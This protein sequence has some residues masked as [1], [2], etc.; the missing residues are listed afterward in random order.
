MQLRANDEQNKHY[1]IASA[2][3]LN[4]SLHPRVD[5]LFACTSPGPSATGGPIVSAAATTMPGGR[6]TCL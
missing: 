2:H 3:A 6:P 4:A 1:D 5:M